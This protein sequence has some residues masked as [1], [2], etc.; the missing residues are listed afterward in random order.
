MQP[1]DRMESEH[2]VIEGFLGF[3]ETQVEVLPFTSLIGPQASGKSVIAKLVFFFRNYIR[4]L[5]LRG[6]TE[7]GGRRAFNKEQHKKFEILFPEAWEKGTQFKILYQCER[8]EIDIEKKRNSSSIKIKLGAK[9]AQIFNTTRNEYRQWVKSQDHDERRYFLRDTF[10]FFRSTGRENDLWM[11]FPSVL[12]VPAK[13]SFFSSIQKNIFSFLAEENRIDP[14]IAQFGRFF[15]RA[16]DRFGDGLYA[17]PRTK[18]DRAQ[19]DRDI[20]KILHGSFCREKDEDYIK[21]TWGGK[22]PLSSASSGQQEALP[23]LLAAALYPV[24]DRLNDL[25]IIEEPE[26]HLYP[27]AQRDALRLIVENCVAGESKLLIT[28]HSPYILTCM[29]N[30]IHRPRQPGIK[31]LVA[32]YYIAEGTAKSVFDE[33]LQIIDIEQI[34]KVSFEIANEFSEIYND[35]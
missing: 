20:A 32:A 14:T 28:T 1:F 6:L 17:A 27:A 26:A 31:P 11:V 3:R 13:R 10:H 34:D 33:E 16:K 7:S 12:L 21:T 19:R 5:Y 15:E 8:T 4:N 23:M 22:V 9:E 18:R 30:E 25:L 29:N 24:K 35:E 2:L